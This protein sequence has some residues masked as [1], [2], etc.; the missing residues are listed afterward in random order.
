MSGESGKNL[1]SHKVLWRVIYSLPVVIAIGLIVLLNVVS[2]LQIGA[3]GI[4]MVF[5]GFYAFFLSLSFTLIR[6]GA[7][8]LSMVG[9]NRILPPKKTYYFATVIALFPVFLL[10]LN[11]IGQL[12]PLDVL[13]VVALVGLGCFY[14]VRQT[15]I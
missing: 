8:L 15:G 6:A 13:L 12:Q 10:A 14:V 2:P 5:L 7:G 11:S 9:R 1:Q 4:L 3:I